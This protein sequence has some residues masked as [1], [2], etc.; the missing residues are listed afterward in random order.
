VAELCALFAEVEENS[1]TPPSEKRILT[2]MRQ[3]YVLIGTESGKIV[4]TLR[5]TAKKP[6]AIDT[7]YF[8]KSRNPVYLMAMVVT[9]AR[10]RKGLGRKCL[11]QAKRIARS[12][13]ADAIR[14]DAF[15]GKGGAGGFYE[16]C[17][18]AEKGRVSYRGVPLIY[19]ELILEK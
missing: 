17:G 10:Q 18:Y 2:T 5:L 11:T 3:S 15:D 8:T 4:A 9:P 16:R 6:W 14:L 12:L 19:Y 1:S 7:N 13:G